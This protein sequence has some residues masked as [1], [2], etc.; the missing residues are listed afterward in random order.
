MPYFDIYVEDDNGE[1]DD[2]IA[3]R[4]ANR[5]RLA[6]LCTHPDPRDPDHPEYDDEDGEGL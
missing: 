1:I 5:R 6:Q 4:N 2:L 3:E